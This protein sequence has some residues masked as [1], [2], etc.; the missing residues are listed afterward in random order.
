QVARKVGLEDAV[1]VDGDGGGRAANRVVAV[2]NVRARNGG[3]RRDVARLIERI[4]Y[5]ATERG[6]RVRRIHRYRRGVVTRVRVQ[7]PEELRLSEAVGVYQVEA[8]VGVGR[9]SGLDVL[10]EGVGVQIPVHDVAHRERHDVLA[11]Q[12]DVEV[13]DGL[14]ILVPHR[15]V[16]DDAGRRNVDHRHEG[17]DAAARDGGALDTV[18]R[19]A[20]V[21]DEQRGTR[22]VVIRAG[23]RIARARY[24]EQDQGNEDGKL[25]HFYSYRWFL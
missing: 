1:A 12:G 14:G 19:H 8:R 18:Q 11:G 20:P 5:A 7:Q 22:H 2:E 10:R 17:V 25:F 13:E 15:H 16:R 24:R 3:E 9:R 21:G 4:P 23:D 6:E